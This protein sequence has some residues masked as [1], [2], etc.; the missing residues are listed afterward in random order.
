[1]KTASAFLLVA[2]LGTGFLG[3][4]GFVNLIGFVPALKKTPPQQIIRFWQIVD[5]YMKVRMPRFGIAILFSLIG[6]VILLLNQPYKQPVWLLVLAVLFIFADIFIATRHNFPF[7]K[8]IQS[9]TPETVPVN[10]EQLRRQSVVGFSTRA[11]CM[12]GSFI[13][14]LT[15]LFLFLS[16]ELAR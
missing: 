5:G 16:K 14:T 15:A 6:S 13:S 3:G 10:F 2:T 9:I 11:I 8:M 1:M 7:N 4:I 12:I